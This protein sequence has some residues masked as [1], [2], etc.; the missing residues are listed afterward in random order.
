MLTMVAPQ[1]QSMPT[2]VTI[3]ATSADVSWTSPSTPNGVLVGYTLLVEAGAE[4]VSIGSY[5]Y[6]A[7]VQ[8]ASVSALLPATA[9]WFT[10]V[11]FNGAGS[12][13]SSSL[14]VMTLE[15]GLI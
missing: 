14:S 2:L 1:G 6:S 9:Y 4:R 10:I 12:V 3:T 13:T 7:S 15:A 11:A 8:Q 5:N